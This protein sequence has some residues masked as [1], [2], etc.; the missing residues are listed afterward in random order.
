[1]PLNDDDDSVRLAFCRRLKATRERSG[2]SLRDIAES[3]KICPSHLGALERGDLRYWPKGFFRRAF[4]RGYVGM[5]GLPV[6]ETV[7]E[8]VQLFPDDEIA[9]AKSAARPTPAADAP[10][11]ALDECWH[12]PTTSFRSRL[13]TSALDM[14]VVILAAVGLAWLMSRDLATLTAIVA[15]SYFTLAKIVVGDT[16]A[17]WAVRSYPTARS[18]LTPIWHRVREPFDSLLGQ[19]EANRIRPHDVATRLRVRFKWSP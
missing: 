6:D 14:A 18:I 3:T 5:I 13:A 8:F 15:T 9:H 2:V 1:M 4:F 17:G 12:G 10:R 19:A 16:P 11:L 7:E